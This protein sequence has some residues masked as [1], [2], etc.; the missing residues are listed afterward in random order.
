M[1]NRQ[2]GKRSIRGLSV[3][4]KQNVLCFQRT[5]LPLLGEKTCNSIV[6][7]LET[8]NS[9]SKIFKETLIWNIENQENRPFSEDA[10]L[11]SL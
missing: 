1:S 9:I 3:H 8:D 10:S 11:V 2:A 5:L 7:S 6:I 4:N